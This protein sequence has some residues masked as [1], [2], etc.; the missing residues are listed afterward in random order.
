M[1]QF[2]LNLSPQWKRLVL[3]ALI[4]SA[5]LLGQVRDNRPKP[6]LPGKHAIASQYAELPLSFEVNQGQADAS[7]KFLSRT[8]GAT[9]FLAPTETVLVSGPIAQPALNYFVAIMIFVSTSSALVRP[10]AMRIMA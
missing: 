10:S 1:V 9:I 8:S 4:V 7:V 5:M 6:L 3:N 2:G